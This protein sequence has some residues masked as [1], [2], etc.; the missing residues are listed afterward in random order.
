MGIWGNLA[1]VRLPD[2]LALLGEQS[3][4]LAIK[5]HQGPL[6]VLEVAHGR[7]KAVREGRRPIPLYRVEER[8]L[9]LMDNPRGR[10][11]FR[12]AAYA[13]AGR[14]PELKGLSVRLAALHK[15]TKALGRRL[16]PPHVRFVLKS[17]KP[18]PNPRWRLLFELAREPLARGSSALELA[19]LLQIPLPL[20]QLLLYEASKARRVARQFNR[21]FHPLKFHFLP[22]CIAPIS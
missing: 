22:H 17:P 4:V 6:L 18:L 15:E 14:G 1:D 12:P 21:R 11:N 13:A 20:A 8:L 7:L 19:E 2:L 9:R 5:P 10:F 3:G 16:P